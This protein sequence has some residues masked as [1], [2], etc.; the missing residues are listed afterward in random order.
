M[1]SGSGIELRFREAG[2]VKTRFLTE[3]WSGRASTISER[4]HGLLEGGG[5]TVAPAVLWHGGGGGGGVESGI[6]TR[7]EAGMLSYSKFTVQATY[8]RDLHFQGLFVEIYG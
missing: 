4:A 6:G 8:L 1:E 3:N 2:K 5:S 7:F